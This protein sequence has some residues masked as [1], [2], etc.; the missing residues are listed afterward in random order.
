MKLAEIRRRLAES[1][2]FQVQFGTRAAHAVALGLTP[3]G[4]LVAIRLD[5]RGEWHPEVVAP[6]MIKEW[7]LREAQR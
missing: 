2:P 7:P 3:W 5:A 1:G 4:V 6:R